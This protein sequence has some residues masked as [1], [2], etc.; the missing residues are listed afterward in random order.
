MNTPQPSIHQ[1]PYDDKQQHEETYSDRAL[2]TALT[3]IHSFDTIIL[4]PQTLRAGLHG[5]RSEVTA[6]FPDMVEIAKDNDGSWWLNADWEMQDILESLKP[7]YAP[8]IPLVSAA[9]DTVRDTPLAGYTHDYW[10]Y[11]VDDL[12]EN[13]WNVLVHTLNTQSNFSS[14]SRTDN[15]STL[16]ILCWVVGHDRLVDYLTAT[17]HSM[18]ILEQYHF[19]LTV[20]QRTDIIRNHVMLALYRT[21]EAYDMDPP[22]AWQSPLLVTQFT[23][24]C[25]DGDLFSAVLYEYVAGH[26]RFKHHDGL[27]V[28]AQRVEAA[29]R[30]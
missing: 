26:K 25:A 23:E 4:V 7:A 17:L 5:L 1:P 13:V 9:A 16:M 28:L 29:E 3:C 15:A 21:M 6:R 20:S 24:H 11:V 10:Q 27:H 19:S 18:F 2:R 8:A 14:S 22:F 30:S 12:R